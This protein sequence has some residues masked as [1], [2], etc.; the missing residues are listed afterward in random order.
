MDAIYYF[1]RNNMRKWFQASRRGFTLLELLVVIALIGIFASIVIANISRGRSGGSDSRVVAELQQAR[2][3]AEF[4]FNDND[5]YGEPGADVNVSGSDCGTNTTMFTDESSPMYPFGDTANY[6][7]GTILNCVQ[8]DQS[9]ALSA[10]LSTQTA[11][12]QDFWCIDSMGASRKI[13][14]MDSSTITE[15]DDSCTKQAL[16]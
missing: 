1:I 4:F 12:K 16:R 10:S 2:T 14:I 3:T 11:G 6:P 8:N 13:S 9:Y 15:T 7:A 5:T